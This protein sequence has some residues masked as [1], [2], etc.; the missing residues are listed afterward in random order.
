M[1]K[2]A[3]VVKLVSTHSHPKVAEFQL[4]F[5]R[6]KFEVST[7]SHPKVADK[8]IEAGERHLEFQHTATRR[9]L[10]RKRFSAS[11]SS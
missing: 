8:A 3:L 9:W 6:P 2:P 5:G 4:G 7:H 1:V 11:I 10:R